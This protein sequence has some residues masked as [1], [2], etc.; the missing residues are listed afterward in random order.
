MGAD[1]IIWNLVRRPDGSGEIYVW[2]SVLF[3]LALAGII[4]FGFFL[5]KCHMED[6]DQFS[7]EIIRDMEKETRE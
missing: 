7:Q 4:W 6:I 5:H 1:Q 2:I 3:L